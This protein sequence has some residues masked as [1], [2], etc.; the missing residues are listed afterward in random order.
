MGLPVTTKLNQIGNKINCYLK[1]VTG[2]VA[3]NGT[4][5]KYSAFLSDQILVSRRVAVILVKNKFASANDEY[6]AKIEYY[7][8]Y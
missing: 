6:G 4:N 5:A 1:I 7:L 2:T 3:L 8:N